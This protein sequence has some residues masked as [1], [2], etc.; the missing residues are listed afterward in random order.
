MFLLD[1][2]RWKLLLPQILYKAAL[3]Y[4]VENSAFIVETDVTRGDVGRD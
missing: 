1:F 4:K 2:R 3:S